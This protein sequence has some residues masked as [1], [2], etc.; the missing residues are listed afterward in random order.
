MFFFVFQAFAGGILEK[1][2]PDPE[3]H[4]ELPENLIGVFVH[5]QY[6]IQG[7]TTGD[8]YQIV[9]YENNKYVLSVS[10]GDFGA[11][12]YGYITHENQEYYFNPVNEI[13]GSYITEKTKINIHEKGISFIIS[14]SISDRK[15]EEIFFKKNINNG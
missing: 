1:D 15:G 9:I 10:G 3:S 6:H 2:I 5:Y 11:R 7:D 12:W 14:F 8:K 13:D 4:Y